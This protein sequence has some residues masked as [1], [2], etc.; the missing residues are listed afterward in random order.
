MKKRITSV[1]LCLAMVVGM[2]PTAAFAVESGTE[3]KAIQFGTSGIEDPEK[4]QGEISGNYYS[5]NSYIY[6]G[7]NNDAP[8]KWRV[9]DADKVNDGTTDG[10]FLLSEYFLAQGVKFNDSNDS[11]S[12]VY[13]GSKAQKWCTDFVNSEEPE[14][15]SAAE[16]NAM[17]GIEK[18]DEAINNWGTSAL[19][20]TD[21]LFFLSGSELMTYVA[22]YDGAPTR[23]GT[24]AS[25]TIS[26]GYWWLRSP[27]TYNNDVGVISYDGCT[28]HYAANE[29]LDSR[30]TWVTRPAFNLNTSDVLFISAAEGGKDETGM[31]NGLTAVDDYDG[32]EWKLTLKD[33][34]REFSV[35]DSET[36][37]KAGGTVELTY[38][39]AAVGDNEYISVI[40]EN[41]SNDAA[42]YGRVLNT[43]D[44]E[45][46]SG[47]VDI[48][49]PSNLEYGTYTLHVFSEQYN[50][51]KLTD[52]ASAFENVTLTVT[53]HIHCVCGAEHEVIG[54]H[55]EAQSIDWTAWTDKLA[56]E[57]RGTGNAKAST[58]LPSEEGNYYLTGDVKISNGWTPPNGDTV[59]CLNG[60]SI[61]VDTDEFAVAVE[62]E[63]INFALTDCIGGGRITHAVAED[64]VLTG[65]GVSVV[66]GTFNMYGGEITGNKLVSNP[67]YD[68]SYGSGVYVGSGYDQRS[69]FNMYGGR[70]TG[71]TLVNN[72]DGGDV[73]G[74]GVYVGCY[75]TFNMYNGEISGNKVENTGSDS[76]YGG[77]VYVDDAFYENEHHDIEYNVERCAAFNMSGGT[78]IGNTVVSTEGNACGGGVYADNGAVFTVSGN[79]QIT[80][81]KVGAAEIDTE[82]GYHTDGTENNVQLYPGGTVDTVEYQAGSMQ[83]TGSLTD[84]A[85]IGVSKDT[86]GTLA[87]GAT[88]SGLDY[89]KIFTSDKEG[90][91]TYRDSS[92]NKVKLRKATD[93]KDESDGGGSSSSGGSSLRKQTLTVP[94]SGSESSTKV[95]ASVNG[96]VAT[97]NDITES[98]LEKLGADGNVTIDLS[99]LSGSV[100]GV[101]LSLGTLENMLDS[102]TENL[103]IK[104]PGA[105]V[106]IDRTTLNALTEQAS[107]DDLSLVVDNDTAAHKTLNTAQESSLSRMNKPT[108]IEAY[109]VSGDERI[110]DFKGGTISISIELDADK[111]I[112][113]WYLKENGEYEKVD[114]FYDN[115]TATL[116]LKH[117]SHYVIEQLDDSMGNVSCPKDATC[118]IASFTDA[119]TTAWYHDG[120]HY[121]IKNGLMNGYDNGKFGTNDNISRSQIVTILWRLEGSPAVSGGSFDDVASDAYY[122]KAVAWAAENGI[123]GGY[124]DG[125]F[126]PN[127]PITREQLA[128]IL[129]RY[130]QLKDVDV[131]VGEDTNILD[132]DDAQSISSYAVP[133]IQWACGSGIITGTSVTTLSPDGTA[134]RTQAATMLMRY[135]I[136]IAK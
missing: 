87:S 104:L 74:G 43:T 123:V 12:N 119:Q 113:A 3:V 96:N 31:D 62:D 89:S 133:A 34:N 82:T 9:L 117:F 13:Q 109:F 56:K 136:E 91:E 54:N 114:A 6:F 42:Y 45:S 105:D 127:D 108:V 14:N 75:A 78:I 132:F 53:P 41:S 4:K 116:M 90:Y 15:F 126:G 29:N 68:A 95:S 47:T 77:G 73:Y 106:T 63:K 38:S 36:A 61:I 50:G 35:D 84:D 51:D 129:Y 92:D 22:D 25:M 124:G 39:G 134:T 99:G 121:C 58:S 1:L 10:M 93:G 88:D 128:A 69:T 28:S 100:T 20:E 23:K 94:V 130:A 66:E 11:T 125:R 118:P 70:I 59:L 115:K 103:E 112:C 60:Y 101:K 48:T 16:Q 32:N 98:E 18:E 37:G 102:D 30:N 26:R 19:K 79:V 135:C 33:T 71:N 17:L 76:A 40:L 120:V 131:S 5:P 110:S 27:S 97:V 83:I 7:T 64:G 122:A 86:S 52:Y 85:R 55:I 49:I 111:P 107:A 72:D 67:D 81:N 57:Q 80:G 2:L 8:I 65:G 21:K 46:E 44:E 24:D